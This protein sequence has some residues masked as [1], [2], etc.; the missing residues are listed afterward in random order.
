MS[1]A[2]GLM[3]HFGNLIRLLFTSGNSDG[4]NL[5][6]EVTNK[7]TSIIYCSKHNNNRK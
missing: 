6:I 4:E 2:S 3:A 5:I 7:V 1:E